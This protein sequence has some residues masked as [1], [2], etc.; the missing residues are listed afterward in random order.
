MRAYFRS[1][2]VRLLVLY[3]VLFCFLR[4][5]FA[6]EI[7]PKTLSPLEEK[8]GQAK[9]LYYDFHFKESERLL[10]ETIASLQALPPAP[11]VN[12]DLSE[13]Y[14][15]L[16]LA[17]DAQDKTREMQASLY[18]CVSYEPS[19]NLDPAT[20]SPKI[21]TQFKKA[22]Q[23]FL[24]APSAE[25]SSKLNVSA[26]EAK[27]SANALSSS[28]KKPKKPFY[29]TWPFFVILGV[30]VAGG[31]AGA[32]IALGGGGGGGSGSGPATVGG[33]PQ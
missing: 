31:A 3:L 33:T 9:I 6:A 18:Q 13:A 10:S 7:N 26:A 24:L 27:Q 11:A 22:K 30:V 20:Y 12:H 28:D 29:K 1:G 17:Q 23:K 21:I 32:A 16:A 15:H 25:T 19:R 14:L 5:S 4:T 2:S 8:I